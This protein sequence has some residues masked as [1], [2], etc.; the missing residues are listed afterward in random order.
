VGIARGQRQDQKSDRQCQHC[1]V[2]S[3]PNLLTR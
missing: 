1:R 2:L 3:H